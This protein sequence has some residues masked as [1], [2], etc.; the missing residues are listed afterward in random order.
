MNEGRLLN[1][2]KLLLL[3]KNTRIQD[4]ERKVWRLELELN[5]KNKLLKAE[6]S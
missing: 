2:L 3:G 6:K 1:Q 4:L 5:E